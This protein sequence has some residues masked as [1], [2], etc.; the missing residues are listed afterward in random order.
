MRSVGKISVNG[1]K[2]EPV[3]DLCRGHCD[4]K[5]KGTGQIGEDRFFYEVTSLMIQG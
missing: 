3:A 4:T 1:G 5:L 2:A